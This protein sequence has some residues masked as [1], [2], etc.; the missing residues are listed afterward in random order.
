MVVIIH[1]EKVT[2]LYYVTKYAIDYTIPDFLSSDKKG[3]RSHIYI[4]LL[5]YS[6]QC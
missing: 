4:F 2:A 5:L 6:G 3:Y 1:Q